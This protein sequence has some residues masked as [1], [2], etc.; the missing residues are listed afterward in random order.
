MDFE[1]FYTGGVEIQTN[2]NQIESV[3]FSIN[4]IIGLLFVSQDR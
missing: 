2:L 4:A 1:T 3:N